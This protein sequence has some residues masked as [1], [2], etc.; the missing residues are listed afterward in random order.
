MSTIDILNAFLIARWDAL[1]SRVRQVTSADHA[2]R[3]ASTLEYL[4]CTLLG[5]GIALAVG[6]VV[7]NAINTR[8][9][10]IQ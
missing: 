10:Q 8:T 2:D 9:A 4:I 5:L 7:W 3:G 6:I 1:H